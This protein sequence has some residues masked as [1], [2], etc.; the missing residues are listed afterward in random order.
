MLISF[1][2]IGKVM[3]RH[4]PLGFTLETA[5]ITKQAFKSKTLGEKCSYTWLES[6]LV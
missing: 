4:V 5:R 3:M 1:L 2:F 6:A